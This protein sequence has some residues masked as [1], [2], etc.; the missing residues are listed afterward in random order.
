[1]SSITR[2]EHERHNEPD[3]DKVRLEF[4]IFGAV[5][6]FAN[7]YHS[8]QGSLGYK[9]LSGLEKIGYK[10]GISLQRYEFENTDQEQLYNVLVDRFRFL[11]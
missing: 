1:M 5:W 4:D 6:A 8:G 10:P 9:L 2:R 7:A 11:A 3:M